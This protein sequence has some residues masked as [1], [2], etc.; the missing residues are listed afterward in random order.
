MATVMGMLDR[1]CANEIEPD[2]V[3]ISGGEPTQHP[4]LFEILDA[5]KERPIRHLMLNTNGIR[6][7]KEEGFAERLAA[8][9]PGFEVY[10]QFD[11]LEAESL[12]TL[13]GEDL[14]AVRQ[15]AL[16]RLDAV[17]L[18]TTLV[19]VVRRGVNDDQLGDVIRY[20]ATRSCVRGVSFQL[21]QDA[22][23]A[24]G[25]DP[26]VN[27]VTLT[28]VRRKILEQQEIFTADD[29]IP[30]PCHP[31]CLAMAYALRDGENLV[32]LTGLIDHEVLLDAG[33]TVAFERDPKL[34]AEM[35]KTFS[36]GHSPES[37][38]EA[39]TKLLCCLPTVAAGSATYDQVFRITIIS[40]LDRHNMD[41]RSV[42]KAC[43]FIAHP[44]GKRL[45]PFDTFNV[46]YR[47]G[48][49]REVLTPLRL[50]AS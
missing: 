4:K 14:R 42:R 49:E 11:S 15:R 37:A 17:G 36:L 32:P 26:A 44:D 34:R 50:G 28:E 45:I 43:I 20:A 12:L 33:N 27:R 2:I 8:Y 18:S 48:L 19:V 38:S 47:D 39:L 25:F 3:Q 30:V 23:R 29:L 16:D 9:A 35:F 1:I 6:I 22:G 40:F 24:G 13:R 41:T 46:L 7:A 10:L 31:D 21:E 5:C